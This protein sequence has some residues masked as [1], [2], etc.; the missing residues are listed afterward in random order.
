MDNAGLGFARAVAVLRVLRTIQSSKNMRFYLIQRAYSANE[1]LTF[2]LG[3]KD[4]AEKK[5]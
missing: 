5:D 4:D 1:T 2:G 3:I